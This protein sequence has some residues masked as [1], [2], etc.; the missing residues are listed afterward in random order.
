MKLLKDA[1]GERSVE[2][3]RDDK[4]TGAQAKRP[5]LTALA[6]ERLDLGNCLTA[7]QHEECFS[8]LDPLEDR[9]RITLN[10]IDA[11]GCHDLIL[12]LGLLFGH[13]ISCLVLLLDRHCK[14]T[15]AAARSLSLE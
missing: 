2:I 7:A 8:P 12:D 14:V 6:G 10:L 5:R 15:I 11:D 4:F 3:V 1:L 9:L 13:M